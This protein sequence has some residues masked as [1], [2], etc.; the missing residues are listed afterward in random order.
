M[1]KKN[2]SAYREERGRKQGLERW[3]VKKDGDIAIHGHC[4]KIHNN[5]LQ[6]EENP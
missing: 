2:I 6:N 1:E 5:K 3:K 4:H